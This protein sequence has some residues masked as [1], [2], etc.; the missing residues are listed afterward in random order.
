MSQGNGKRKASYEGMPVGVSKVCINA[1]SAV[2][3]ALGQR[4]KQFNKICV[5]EVRSRIASNQSG[6][7]P[8][9]IAR[10]DI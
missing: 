7:M 4:G 10:L 3:F 1:R 9:R 6:P 8:I 2:L 5:F